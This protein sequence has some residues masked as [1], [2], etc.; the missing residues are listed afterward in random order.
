MNSLNRRNIIRQR[1][2]LPVKVRIPGTSNWVESTVF[3]LNKTGICILSDIPC[4]PGEKIEVNKF[5]AKEI[6]PAHVV[7]C[8]PIN[9][10]TKS[11]KEFKV[12]IEYSF[13]NDTDSMPVKQ[14]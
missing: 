8:Q 9:D 11:K 5:Q 12:G 10:M 6:I 2:L 13:N 14:I 7:W 4:S 1:S 3:N